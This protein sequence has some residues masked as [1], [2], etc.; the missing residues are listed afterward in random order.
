VAEGGSVYFKLFQTSERILFKYIEL[1]YN[2]RRNT[3]PMAGKLL[4]TKSNNGYV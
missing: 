1:Y 3:Q 2:Q 4:R